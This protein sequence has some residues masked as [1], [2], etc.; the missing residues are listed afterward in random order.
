[1][2]IKRLITASVLAF[3]CL[4]SQARAPFVRYGLEWGFNPN[5][6]SHTNLNFI[7]FEGYRIR[8]TRTRCAFFPNGFILANVGINASDYLSVTVHFGYSGISRDNTAIPA[9]LRVTHHIKGCSQDGPFIFIDGGAGFHIAR[10]D[11]PT[12]EPA[13][14][15][16]AGFG[17]KLRLSSGFSLDFAF[18]ITAVRD[19]IAIKDPDT[20]QYIGEENIFKNGAFYLNPCISVGFGF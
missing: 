6:F 5:L 18:S 12:R 1:M 13:L 20:G 4:C 17:Y 10:A 16:D 7:S 19:H 14:M 15:G 8:D 11:E 9:L 2:N 3:V